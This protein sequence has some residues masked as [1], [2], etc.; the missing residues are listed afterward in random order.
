MSIWLPEAGKAA[1]IKFYYFMP[2][3]Q[4]EGL[5]EMRARFTIWNGYSADS[6]AEAG[7][8][9]WPRALWSGHSRWAVPPPGSHLPPGHPELYRWFPSSLS[10]AAVASWVT[11]STRAA[12]AQQNNSCLIPS[13]GLGL[14]KVTLKQPPR[15]L[16]K[17]ASY[18]HF[19]SNWIKGS[20]ISNLPYF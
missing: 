7:C 12:V 19:P 18:F 1:D 13:A 10:Q 15:I 8:A 4:P 17:R 6:S 14:G 20:S 9:P 11:N 3:E 16:V 2:Q 5:N